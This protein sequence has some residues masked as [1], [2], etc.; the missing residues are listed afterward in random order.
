MRQ[1]GR[2]LPEYRAIRKKIDF[3][4]LCKT[5]ETAAEVT[6][7]P[8]DRLGVDA[9][10]LFSD[11]LVPVEPMGFNI[12]FN[13]G[14]VLDHAVRTRED[15]DNIRITD[16]EET[17]PF[18]YETI[19]ILRRELEGRVPLIGFAAAPFT[20]ATYMVEG[21]GSK[22]FSKVKKLIF[23]EPATAHALLEKITV[24]T[25]KY[26]L[27]Q[28]KA[29]AQAVQLFDSWAGLLST[30]DFREFGMRYA[31]RV[32]DTLKG[33]GVPRIYFALN[34]AHLL[35]E[36]QDCGAEVIGMDWRMDLVESSRRL[37]GRYVLQGNLDPAV[38]LSGSPETIG[39]KARQVVAAG[40]NLPG[41]IFNLGHGIFPDTPV[42]HAQALV[43]AVQS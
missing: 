27:A 18:V 8:V 41:H 16:P 26:L 11:I 25:E 6:I 4:T 39:E 33:A 36:I 15:V 40:Q 10:I 30:E 24:A 34:N 43:Q 32:L 13:P 29:G 22:N 31:R 7:Q 37:A 9:A 23:A 17:V 1:A 28:V 19:R 14:P 21:Q 12:S 2:Y 20:L 35:E 5:P 38:L 3:V 42:E